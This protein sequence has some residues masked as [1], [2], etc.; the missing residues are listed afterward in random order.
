MERVAQR[1]KARLLRPGLPLPLRLGR[2]EHEVEMA[3]VPSD[4]VGHHVRTR[5]HSVGHVEPQNFGVEGDKTL[6]VT[7]RG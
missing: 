3:A 4:E 6:Q 1:G 7:C 2:D 5:S